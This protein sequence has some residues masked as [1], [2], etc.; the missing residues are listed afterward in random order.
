MN[1]PANISAG[2]AWERYL[3]TVATFRPGLSEEENRQRAGLLLLRDLARDRMQVA[4]EPAVLVLEVIELVAA[5]AAFSGLAAEQLDIVR[6]A[7]VRLGTGAREL[8]K[9]FGEHGAG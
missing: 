7:L 5:R 9:V 1:A 2:Y 8:E 3:P 6:L 4:S